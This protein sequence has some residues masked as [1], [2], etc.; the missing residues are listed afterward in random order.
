MEEDTH[1]KLQL[2][3]DSKDARY[4]KKVDHENLFFFRRQ[5]KQTNISY[6]NTR[7]QGF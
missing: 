7:R 3:I 6:I 5:I 1:K 4:G 2:N